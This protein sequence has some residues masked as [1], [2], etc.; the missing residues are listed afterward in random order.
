MQSDMNEVM[1]RIYID[2][3]STRSRKLARPRL[4]EQPPCACAPSKGAV[5]NSPEV[6]HFNITAASPLHQKYFTSAS[7]NS[8]FHIQM[9]TFG[10]AK[11][12]A[13]KR[14]HLYMEQ[15]FITGV[16]LALLW[17]CSGASLA[18]NQSVTGSASANRYRLYRRSDG[19]QLKPTREPSS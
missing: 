18:L 6:L 5:A 7:S 19:R 4:P 10:S 9:Q 14:V 17:R 15:S 8:I 16:A 1:A 11:I 3:W 12:S 13:P 2:L